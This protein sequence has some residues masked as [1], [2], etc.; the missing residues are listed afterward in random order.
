VASPRCIFGLTSGHASVVAHLHCGSE[1]CLHHLKSLKYPC[2][3]FG[4][5][6]QADEEKFVFP[7]TRLTNWK[8]GES[9]LVR[10]VSLRSPGLVPCLLF[11]VAD[12]EM[13]GQIFSFCT[14]PLSVCT[15]RDGFRLSCHFLS[16]T[17]TETR[18]SSIA[19]SIE[20]TIIPSE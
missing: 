19:P 11:V 1:F 16:L 2:F 3:V 5:E 6:V 12:E 13:V 7:A 10:H 9:Y 20:L 8:V 4:V 18:N 17:A 14:H 15:T